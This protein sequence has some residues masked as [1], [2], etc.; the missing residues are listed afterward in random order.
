MRKKIILNENNELSINIYTDKQAERK[1]I[2]NKIAELCIAFPKMEEGFWTI[3][4]ERIV[5]NN[6]TAER[7]KNAVDHVLDNF[8]Y[9]ELNIADI[10]KFDKRVKLYTGHEFMSAQ[11]SGISP[12]DFE[13]RVIENETYWI[14][15]IDL[16]K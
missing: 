6:F 7:L 13:K 10:I 2:A 14:K 12:N 16:V 3:L 8:Q 1:E 9:K 11:A 5:A 4:T 15:K